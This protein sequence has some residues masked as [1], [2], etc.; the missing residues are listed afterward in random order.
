[1]DLLRFPSNNETIHLSEISRAAFSLQLVLAS[2]RQS[3]FKQHALPQ[4]VYFDASFLLPAIVPGHPFNKLYSESIDRLLQGAHKVGGECHLCVGRP[5]L[6]EVLSH[7]N[8]AIELAEAMRV[9]DLEEFKKS[10]LAFGAENINVFI[11]GFSGVSWAKERSGEKRISFQEYLTANAPYSSEEELS[12]YLH[13]LGFEVISID[14]RNQNNSKYSSL[15]N[16]LLTGYEL[17]NHDFVRG[18]ERVLV[19]HE[20]LQLLQMSLD[21]NSGVRSVFV[22]NDRKLRRAAESVQSTKVLSS[23]ILPPQG[24]IGLVDIVV[25]SRPDPR[26]LA[27]LLWASSRRDTDQILRDYLVKRALS[28]QDVAQAKAS[29][30]VINEII[31]EAKSEAKTKMVDLSDNRTAEAAIKAINFVDRF[32][33]RFF[34]KMRKAIERQEK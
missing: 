6:D 32:E 3:L 4:R 23:G 8:R 1:V 22:S 20:A 11:G 12:K 34:E 13:N 21:L 24:F 27:R 10:I 25:G 2:P 26:G 18:K 9:N 19:E 30:E 33:D 16:G 15:F 29:A 28:E 17:L 14:S 5:F 31:N 7:R